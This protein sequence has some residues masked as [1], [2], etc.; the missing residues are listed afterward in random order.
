MDQH[1]QQ[2]KK[3]REAKALS[4]GK[5]SGGT[6]AAEL[7]FWS[8]GTSADRT[9]QPAPSTHSL[10]GTTPLIPAVI[11][12]IGIVALLSSGWFWQNL[13]ATRN[14]PAV[15]AVSGLFRKKPAHVPEAMVWVDKKSGFYYCRGDMLF[16]RGQGRLMA[17]GEA[18]MSG[19]QPAG[20]RYCTSGKPN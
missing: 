8:A 17:Q 18:L 15:Q 6:P 12:I 20:G 9:Y 2:G 3:N 13:D 4:A 11:L 7:H 14:L 5:K 1:A 10:L 19:Y 16:G